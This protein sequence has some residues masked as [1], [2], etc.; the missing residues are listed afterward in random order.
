MGLHGRHQIP[1][2]VIFLFSLCCCVVVAMRD[3][4]AL[5]AKVVSATDVR[6]KHKLQREV[7][8]A[9]WRQQ[10]F[11]RKSGSFGEKRKTSPP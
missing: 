4:A 6:R 11:S 8:S 7:F 10:N 9:S 2:D 1:R 5:A 3:M